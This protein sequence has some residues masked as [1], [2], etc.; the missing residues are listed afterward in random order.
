MD[1]KHKMKEAIRAT[2]RLVKDQ[3]ILEVWDTLASRNFSFFR[4]IMARIKSVFLVVSEGV[5]L[6]KMRVF[7]VIAVSE[8]TSGSQSQTVRKGNGTLP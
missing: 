2:R 7:N 3:D 8:N 4:E 6:L 1:R 5:A